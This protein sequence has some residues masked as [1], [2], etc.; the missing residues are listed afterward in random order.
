MDSRENT[1]SMHIGQ[2]MSKSRSDQSLAAAAWDGI[3]GQQG[4]LVNLHSPFPTDSPSVHSCIPHLV[5]LVSVYASV[6]REFL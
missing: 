6:V 5:P 3:W 4:S 1:H 2:P